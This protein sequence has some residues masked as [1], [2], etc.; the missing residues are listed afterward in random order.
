MFHRIRFI[1]LENFSLK[2]KLDRGEQTEEK[3]RN[4]AIHK[5]V[6]MNEI[7]NRRTIEKIEETK[8]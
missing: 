8:S 5:K 3:Q 7:E 6:E 2:K 1:K 4:E